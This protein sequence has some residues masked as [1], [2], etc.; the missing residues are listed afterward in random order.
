MSHGAAL[1]RR[2][3]P[4]RAEA[5]RD[6]HRRRPEE[7]PEPEVARVVVGGELRREPVD[8]VGDARAD[9]DED[10]RGARGAAQAERGERDRGEDTGGDPQ[11]RPL[12][13]TGLPGRGGE[14]EQRHPGGDR[15]HGD[16]LPPTHV[17]AQP[18]RGDAEEED[19]ARPQQRLDERERRLRQRV[20]LDDPAD[21]ADRR[22]EHPAGPAD[23]A[24][25]EGE[26]ERT[27]GR[28]DARLERLERDADGVERRRGERGEDAGQERG[29]GRR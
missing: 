18:P 1:Q 14:R 26:A 9:R 15:E 28:G 11:S 27:L 13:V 20:R 22:A 19:E 6:P 24:P 2:H 23:E 29:H 3:L 21:E 12:D 25:E 10:A 4:E 5:R 16:L 7:K 17:L 8:R